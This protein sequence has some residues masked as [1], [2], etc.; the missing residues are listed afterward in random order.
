[1]CI[2]ARKK[3]R[4][5]PVKY[6]YLGLMIVFSNA[7]AQSWQCKNE[8]ESQCVQGHCEVSKKGEFT[9]MSVSFDD[10]GEMKVCA[11]SGCWEGRGK[12]FST[13]EFLTIAGSQLELST[14]NDSR[15]NILISLDRSDNIAILKA[16]EFAHPLQ[17]M[18]NSPTFSDYSVPVS[19]E[20]VHAINF[21]GNAEAWRF[22]TRLRDAQKG[23]VNFGGH[24]IFTSW[25]CGASCV[26]GAL[27]N[28][29]NG[30]VFFP[31]ELAGVGT[32]NIPGSLHEV[33]ELKEGSRLFILH[34]QP[35]NKAEK[36]VVSTYLIWEGTKFRVAK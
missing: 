8:F 14:A 18:S 32:S 19:K 5:L 2:D 20:K 29:K 31:K 25:G 11:Y 1:L 17:C 3:N 26:Q 21:K 23:K 27:I 36:I 12:V 34:G 28:T 10:Q 24:F 15:E 16:G 9:P 7:S 4:G 22:R 35:A 30:T 33:W 13:P 6:F